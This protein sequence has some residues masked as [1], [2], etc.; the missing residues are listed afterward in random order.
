MDPATARQA[1]AKAEQEHGMRRQWLWTRM[2][3]AP[4]ATARKQLAELA[5]RSAT[6][7]AG[8]TPTDLATRYQESG[9]QV[10]QAAL[11]ALAAGHTKADVEA[12]GKAVRALYL[13]WLEEAARRLQDAVTT[14]GGLPAAP[15]KDDDPGTGT[16]FVEGLTYEVGMALQ[17]QLNA[18]G[19]TT[20]TATYTTL[21]QKPKN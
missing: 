13:P 17:A 10:D 16:V 6:L 9:W 4:L 21:P 12:V 2:G 11:Q 7:P 18:L 14:A 20:P 5:S 3:R 19:H 1:T 15:P 8:T